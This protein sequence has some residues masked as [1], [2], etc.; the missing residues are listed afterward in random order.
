[1]RDTLSNQVVRLTRVKP[2]LLTT[3][4]NSAYGIQARSPFLFPR[5]CAESAERKAPGR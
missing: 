2:P 4:S 1:V 3:K 5:H